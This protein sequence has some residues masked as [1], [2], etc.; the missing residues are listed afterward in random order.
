MRGYNKHFWT[1][2]TAFAAALL[3]LIALVALVG[4]LYTPQDP[5]QID[6]LRRFAPP[7]PGNWLGRD[8][9]GRDVLSRMLRGAGITLGVGLVASLL[10]TVLGTL[11]GAVAGYKGGLWDAFAMRCADVMMCIPT[12]YLVLTLIVIL[13]PGIWKVVFV[14]AVTGWT[15]MARLVRAEVLSLRERD[16]VLAARASGARSLSVLFRHVLPNA[17]APVYVALTFGVSGAMLLESGLSLLGLGVQA[18]QASWGSLLNSGREAMSEAWW[19]SFFPGLMIFVVMLLVNQ[20]GE[21]AREYF[22]PKGQE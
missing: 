12:L 17:M 9:L 4:V 20:V 2:F 10:S 3:L 18:P 14:I 21:R 7:G 5:N 19:L 8:E 13:G 1:P 11:I 15:G 22:D 6:V 16:Y